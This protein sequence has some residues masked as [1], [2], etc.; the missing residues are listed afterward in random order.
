LTGNSAGSTGKAGHLGERWVVAELPRSVA[1]WD[2]VQAVLAAEGDLAYGD[3]DLAGREPAALR[4]DQVD[5]RYGDGPLVL[6]GLSFTVPP[7]RTVALVGATG[8][9][10]STI[11]SL[12]E[13][14]ESEKVDD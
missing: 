6:R 3:I 11:A 7:G 10:K 12:A 13:K 4:F 2:R 9:G 1:G 5:F 14:A 8:S